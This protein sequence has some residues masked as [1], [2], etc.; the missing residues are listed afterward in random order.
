MYITSFNQKVFLKE[1]IESVINQ[2][3]KPLEII[4][5]DDASSD[6]SQELIQYY[7]NKYSNWISAIYNTTNIGISSVRNKAILAAKGDYITWVDGDDFIFPTKLEKELA[8]MENGNY[9]I[10]FTNYFVAHHLLDNLIQI[11]VSDINL[12]PPRGNLFKE[13]I[14][15]SFPRGMLYRCE[16]INLSFLRRHG[17]YDEF[18]NIFEDYDLRI[19][20]SHIAKINYSLEP[21]SIYRLQSNGLSNTSFNVIH[22]SF[23]YIFKKNIPLVETQSEVNQQ[24]IKAKLDGLLKEMK[25]RQIQ[26][27]KTLIIM[28]VKAWIFRHLKEILGKH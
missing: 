22:D 13:V 3:E 9:D 14:T 1:A 27:S 21:L 25:S 10:V 16:L 26:T 15:R 4:I 23:Q 5:I 20:L 17:I 6:G 11:W 18:L 19:R 12:L 24:E 2:T 7:V 28:K 8:L